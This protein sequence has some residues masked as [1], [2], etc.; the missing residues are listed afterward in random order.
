MVQNLWELP[1][2]V[3]FN[4][5]LIPQEGAHVCHCLD[6]QGQRLGQF[7]DLGQVSCLVVIRY[8]SS[9]SRLKWV[10][11]PT[12]RHHLER[13]SKLHISVGSLPQELRHP[14]GKGEERWQESKGME[15]TRKTCSSESTMQGLTG[16]QRLKQQAQGLHGSA[17]DPLCML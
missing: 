17:P 4:L 15:D 12:D 14:M 11:R 7:R 2:N 8:V 5:K 9:C 1:T 3:R 13:E 16:S 6:Y 10:Q